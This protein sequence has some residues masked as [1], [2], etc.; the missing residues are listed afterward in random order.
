MKGEEESP[1]QD[2]SNKETPVNQEEIIN[3]QQDV[4][5]VSPK[6]SK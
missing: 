6:V 2:Q 3:D 4:Q 5:E 1:E